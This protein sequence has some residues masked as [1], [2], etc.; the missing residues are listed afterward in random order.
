MLPLIYTN[1]T[2]AGVFAVAC[3]IWMVPEWFGWRRQ[4]S[5]VSRKGAAAED[6]GSMAILVVLQWIGLA[7][8]FVLAWMWRAAAITWQPVAVFA[9]GIAL[10]PIGVGLRWYSIRMLGE[11]FTRDVAVAADQRV[12]ER[13]PYRYLRHPSYS[14]TFV[15]MLGVGLATGNWAGAI[16]LLACVFAGHYYRVRVEEA[17]LVRTLGQPY[18]QYMQRTKRF[19]PLVF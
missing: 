2:A 1:G 4:M 3:L 8:N 11:Y 18:L 16:C 6:R 5:R 19:I 17:A 10:I 13:G 9:V 15:T 14:G 7:L 12:V